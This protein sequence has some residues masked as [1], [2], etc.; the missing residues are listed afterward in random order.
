MKTLN[1]TASVVF[2]VV[3]S[4]PSDGK[5]KTPSRKRVVDAL[6]SCVRKPLRIECQEVVDQAIDLYQR[7]DKIVL[8]PLL[9]LGLKSDG[10]MSETLGIFF[11]ED[12]LWKN[13]RLFLLSLVSRP[14]Q[15]QRTLAFLAGAMDG[16]GMEENVFRDVR[17]KLL[18]ISR[19]ANDPL[20]SIAKVCLSS[21]VQAN[22]R[23]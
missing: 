13:P 17:A 15:Q 20:S 19:R 2:L 18:R 10:H 7:G 6:H 21:V 5:A 22:R 11:G 8:N 1:L 12:V 14:K 3:F 23:Q 4:C 9:D 16:G